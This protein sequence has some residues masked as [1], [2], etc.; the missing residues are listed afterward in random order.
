MVFNQG[1]AFPD[2]PWESEGKAKDGAGTGG[3][4]ANCDDIILF[5][6]E[7]R[8]CADVGGGGTGTV[9]SSVLLNAGSCVGDGTVT[10]AFDL[11]D[12]CAEAVGSL[13]GLTEIGFHSGANDWS[14]VVEWNGEGAITAVNDGSDRFSVTVDPESY[15]GVPLAD[16]NNIFFVLNQGPAFPDAPWDSEAKAQ[17]DGQCID[18]NVT[19]SELP[20]CSMAAAEVQDL[21]LTFE[22]DAIE[23]QLFGFGTV[24]F[25]AIPV[26]VSYTH[27]TLPTNREV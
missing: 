18:F 17:G 5:A 13:A 4:D 22:S 14:S 10:I 9:T 25:M 19:I 26:A 3:L 21:P 8:N 2:A 12:N 1:P 15:Y 16:L 23:H 24:D 11:T 6:S 7:L 27:L 20:T